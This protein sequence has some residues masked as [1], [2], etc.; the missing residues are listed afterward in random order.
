MPMV[1]ALPFVGSLDAYKT[2]ASCTLVCITNLVTMRR[3]L[4]C[5]PSLAHTYRSARIGPYWC[6]GCGIRGAH[7]P[8][9]PRGHLAIMQLHNLLLLQRIPIGQGHGVPR[10]GRAEGMSSRMGRGVYMVSNTGPL[11]WVCLRVHCGCTEPR[12]FHPN[13]PSLPPPPPP[14]PNGQ[15]LSG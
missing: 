13:I 8:K 6:T 7:D 4:L 1:V 14:P 11:L 9:R 10:F 3:I 12:M 2:S 5:N 15:W